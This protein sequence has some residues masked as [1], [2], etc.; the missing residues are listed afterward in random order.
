MTG[1]IFENLPMRHQGGNTE[2]GDRVHGG[3]FIK[4]RFRSN[5]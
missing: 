5:L 4:S 1:M 2:R 3:S